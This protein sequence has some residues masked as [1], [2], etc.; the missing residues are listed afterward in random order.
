MI[1]KG[2]RT[3]FLKTI[4]N[5]LLEFDYELPI[6]TSSIA[7]TLLI[8]IYLINT[9]LIRYKSLNVYLFFARIGVP[10]HEGSHLFV[11]LLALHKVDNV[12]FYQNP[13]KNTRS[14]GFVTHRYRIKWLSPITQ[15]L[16]GIAPLF[17]G[18]L[19]IV[20]F[21]NLLAP[22]D[23]ILSLFSDESSTP[24]MELAV[25]FVWLLVCHGIASHLIPSKGDMVGCLKGAVILLFCMAL[26]FAYTDEYT[27]YIIRTLNDGAQ[28]LIPYLTLTAVV[29]IISLALLILVRVITPSNLA[30]RT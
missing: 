18:M 17:G 10:F 1:G 30:N 28:W 19:A 13:Q 5:N 23:A 20:L 7:I 16:I 14:L 24:L 22:Y 25:V 3:S 2:G 4:P 15:L 6:N 26:F 11:A 9:L 27:A 8:F 29:Q 21:T 12:V